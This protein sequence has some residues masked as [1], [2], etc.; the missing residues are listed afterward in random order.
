[1]AIDPRRADL[2]RFIAEDPGGPVVML[3]LLRFQPE[4]GRARY[5]A[6]LRAAAPHVAKVGGEVVY[7]GDGGTA[8]IGEAGQG[9]D[10]VLLVRYPERRALLAMIASPDYQAITHLRSEALVESLLQATSPRAR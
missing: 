8:L 5:D 4:G 3:N 9:W 7:F 6:Y 1:M 2:E 10:A